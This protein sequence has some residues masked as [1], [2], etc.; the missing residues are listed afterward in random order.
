[1]KQIVLC[2]ALSLLGFSSFAQL[3]IKEEAELLDHSEEVM[4]YFTNSQFTDAFELLG[5]YWPLPENEISSLELQTVKQFNMVSDRFGNIVDY[6]FIEKQ[7]V[8][9]ILT[10]HIYVI[11]MERHLIRAIFT[12]YNNGEGWLVNSFKWDDNISDL[13]D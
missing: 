4:K 3:F 1:M 2:I 8:E 12:Y 9:G 7:Q 5:A 11:K 6:K 13:L 10:R